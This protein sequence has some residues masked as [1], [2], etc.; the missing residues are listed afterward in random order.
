MA[1]ATPRTWTTG[2][3][4][5]AAQFNQDMRDNFD[6]LNGLGGG[7]AGGPGPWQ[8]QD[9][10]ATASVAHGVSVTPTWSI[11]AAGTGGGTIPYGGTGYETGIY[12]SSS[13]IWAVDGQCVVLHQ[14]RENALL[15]EFHSDA[16]YG[17]LAGAPNSSVGAIANTDR[18]AKLTAG[19]TISLLG[20]HRNNGVVTLAARTRGIR[21]A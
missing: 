4:A 6:Y 14:L 19:G 2:D 3:V 7:P 5:T 11:G 17:R 21:L 8:W 18:L 15:V 10:G 13:R 20:Q 12:F 9:Q 16:W 1:W